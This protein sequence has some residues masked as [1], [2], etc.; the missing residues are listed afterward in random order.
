MSS[1]KDPV[2]RR[3]FLKLGGA[4]ALATTL[5]GPRSDTAQAAT[6]VPGVDMQYRELGSRTKLKV[7]EIGF[8]GF[9]VND[10]DVIRYAVDRGINY[11]DT[12]WDYRKGK[13]EEAIGKGLKGIRDKVVLTTKW[14][15]WSRT[16]KKEMMEMLNTSL[17]R[18]QT[19]YVDCLLV[20]QV[21]KASGGESIA[22]LENQE[23]YE[24]YELAKK[25]GK[26]RFTGVSGHDGDLME[27]MN[28]VVTKGYFDVILMRYNFLR[29]PEQEKL[30]ERAKQ[31]GIG[32]IAM[33]TLTGAKGQGDP[34]LYRKQGASFKQ[35]ALK[36]VL[37][38]S[39]VSNL[40]ISISSKGQVDEYASASGAKF[41]KAD[42]EVIDYYVKTYG[43]QICTMC[44]ECE[45]HCPY[46]VPV[47]NILRYYMYFED[48]H[49]EE[50]GLR[51]YAALPRQVR[52]DACI[53]CAAP[54][55]SKCRSGVEI[56]RELL[57]AHKALNDDS[58]GSLG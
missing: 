15:P 24:A 37:S 6:W 28:W 41:A 42:Q 18:L 46:E 3:D 33:K 7:S 32:V 1:S 19:D 51:A 12:A 13:S 22:R 35:A 43:D 23:L 17:R 29:Y 10:P 47:A 30:I 50:R 53:N 40:I 27:V 55:E 38:N 25:Q 39:N 11:I 34:K 52:G 2:S 44:N 58:S 56:K 45:P 20:H 9:G 31:A 4:G 54:C 16:S 26:V 5:V 57:K 36:W 8:G 48:Y 21:G 49:E 14:H